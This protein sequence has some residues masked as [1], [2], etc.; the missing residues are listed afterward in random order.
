MNAFLS[1]I[2]PGLKTA[3]PAVSPESRA[4]ELRAAGEEFCQRSIRSL[5][6]SS[7]TGRMLYQAHMRET[8]LDGARGRGGEGAVAAGG[9]R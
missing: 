3:D 6:L 5:H 7:K 8:L 1:G 2:F 4:D 9:C